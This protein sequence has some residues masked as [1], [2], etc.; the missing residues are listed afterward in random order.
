MKKKKKPPR[1]F[2]CFF[3]FCGFVLG[4]WGCGGVCFSFSDPSHKSLGHYHCQISE[5]AMLSGNDVQCV[6]SCSPNSAKLLK[7]KKNKEKKNTLLG[8]CINS[9]WPSTNGDFRDTDSF[10]P[11]LR[12]A[13]E[14]S[15]GKAS[16]GAK[17]LLCGLECWL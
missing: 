11:M 12:Y 2:W 14:E 13:I 8:L 3:C 15:T 5:A 7:K 6:Y 4:V 17:A 1:F 16:L 9:K 10:H